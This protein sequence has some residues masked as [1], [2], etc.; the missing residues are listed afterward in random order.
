MSLRGSLIP[1]PLPCWHSNSSEHIE[2]CYVITLREHDC[3]RTCVGH[4]HKAAS[5]PG[6]GGLT[7]LLLD[8]FPCSLTATPSHTPAL[9]TPPSNSSTVTL[10]ITHS[11]AC[12]NAASSALHIFNR[13]H[14]H[15]QTVCP[16]ICFVLVWEFL[17]DVSLPACLPVCLWGVATS[18]PW[19]CPSVSHVVCVWARVSSPDTN[20]LSHYSD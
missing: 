10:P 16:L 11:L 14:S 8:F 13:S 19:S 6:S 9:T 1:P 3:T 4:H 15:S 5:L 17:F 2:C 20:D 7:K 12:L 18:N